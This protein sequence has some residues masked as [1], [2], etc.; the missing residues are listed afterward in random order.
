MKTNP[1]IVCLSLFISFYSISHAERYFWILLMFD[2]FDVQ[3]ACCQ[4]RLDTQQRKHKKYNEILEIRGKTIRSLVHVDTL[5]G[6]AIGE[7]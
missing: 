6:K 7:A 4:I 5:C 2:W 3:I 1:V